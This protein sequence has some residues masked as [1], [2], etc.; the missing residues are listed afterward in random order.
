MFKTKFH[1]NVVLIIATLVTQVTTVFAAPALQPEQAAAPGWIVSCQYSHSLPDDPIVVFRQPGASHMHDFIG[2]TNTDAFSTAASLAAGGTT[3]AIPGDESAY[4]VPAL[5]EN[6][7]RVL[8]DGAAKHALF[9]YR[10]KGA[11]TGTLVQPFPM[12]LRMIIGN[13]KA[14]SPQENPQLGKDIIFKCGP[15]ST[16]DLPAPPTSCS[17]GIMV[18]SLRFPNCWDGK[19][20]DS[21][22]HKSH[23]AYPSGSRCPSTHPVVLPRIES[24][25]RYKVGTGP[26]G[27]ITLSSGPY[28]TA[29]QDFFNAWDPAVL[30]KLVT[31]CMNAMVD[32]GTNPSVSG[33]SSAAVMSANTLVPTN[34][35]IPTKTPTSIPTNTPLPLPTNTLAP[36]FTSE[37][38]PTDVPTEAPT[39]IPPTAEPTQPA[40]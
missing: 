5:F 11:P 9:Y 34:T 4:W 23:M 28:Y 19:N 18:V 35:A 33:M 26:I 38:P 30:Q 37:P 16:T 36:T 3:C 8:P 25:I 24:F 1:I 31:N 7:V 20:L 21:P 27:T 6:G 39:E 22:D 12:G 10:R 29:H 15:G 13:A 40:P 2:A 17:S 32:C 14:K